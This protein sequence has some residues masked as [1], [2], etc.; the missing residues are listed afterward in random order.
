MIMEKIYCPRLLIITG[1]GKN[2][3]KTTLINSLIPSLKTIHTLV[4]IKISPH[5][6]PVSDNE[7]L[8]RN[9][10]YFLIYEEKSMQSGNDS[11]KMK[12]A[13]AHKVFYIQSK[14]QYADEAFL[15]CLEYVEDNIPV[16]CESGA[17]YKK[18]RPGLM[19][20]IKKE[21]KRLKTGNSD[22]NSVVIMRD[23]D[24]FKSVVDKISFKSGNWEFL[25]HME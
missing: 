15:R 12:R 16:I 1:S 8:F 23:H 5:F 18:I 6:H 3:G 4:A 2:V 13:G 25:S 7:E 19:I 21:E 10:G 20:Y 9:P 22:R 24:H 11:S 14:N 17:L